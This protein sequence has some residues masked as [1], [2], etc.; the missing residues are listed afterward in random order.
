LSKDRDRR[1]GGRRLAGGCSPPFAGARAGEPRSFLLYFLGRRAIT[2]LT[3]L[4]VFL[5][6]LLVLGRQKRTPEPVVILAA[7]AVGLF[8]RGF[9]G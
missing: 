3:T 9:G 6:T 4:M 2:D 5:A 1:K 7:G 8:S